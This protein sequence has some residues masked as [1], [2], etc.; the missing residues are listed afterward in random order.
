MQNP[1][2]PAGLR[3]PF[4][5]DCMYSPCSHSE[6]KCSSE[7]RCRRGARWRQRRFEPGTGN[8]LRRRR[9]GGV[10][11]TSWGHHNRFPRRQA[12]SRRV[13]PYCPQRHPHPWG[14]GWQP[15][16]GPCRHR[17]SARPGWLATRPCRCRRSSKRRVQE[18]RCIR[19]SC[20]QEGRLRGG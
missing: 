19:R 1:P 11:G 5:R 6:D 4:L 14:W 8:R 13:C 7:H 3:R 16:P 17:L 2:C 9:S 12:R 15:G 20:Q 18:R 10:S